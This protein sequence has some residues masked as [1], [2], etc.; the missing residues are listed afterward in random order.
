VKPYLA[1]LNARAR[2]L[3]QYRTA[4]MAGVATQIFWGWIRVSVFT[5]FYA[6]GSA[7]P[8]LSLADT[9]TYLWLTQALLV[10]LPMRVDG[11]VQAMVRDGTVAYELVRPADLYW[12]WFTRQLAARSVPTMLRASTLVLPAMLLFDMGLPAGLAAAGWFLLG[13]AGALLLSSAFSTLMAITLLWTVS[14]EGIARLMALVGQFLSGSYIPV[15]LFPAWSQAALAA[16]PFRGIMDTPFRLYLGNLSGMAA[17]GALLHQVLWTLALIAAG[18]A[19]LS[20][21]LSRLVV[22]GG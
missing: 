9:V 7:A 4:A 22:Q 17:A 18:R 16:L 21:G 8:P 11:E 19:L 12:Y 2:V 6:S 20:R 13:L 14:G 3:L 15:L 5:A 10:L 1:V